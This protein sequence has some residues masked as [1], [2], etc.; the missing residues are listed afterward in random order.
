MDESEVLKFEK[1]KVLKLSEAIRIGARLRPQTRGTL[2]FNGATCA[3]GAAYEAA[4]GPLTGYVHQELGQ[5]YYDKL[6]ALWPI[7]GEGRALSLL[8]ERIV[9]NNDRYEF[10]REEIADWLEAQGF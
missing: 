8:G 6:L 4:I 2:Y 10:S 5:S 3:L 1:Q 7:L 9:L